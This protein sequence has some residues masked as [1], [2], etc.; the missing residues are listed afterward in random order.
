MP[1]YVSD[2]LKPIQTVK[3][4]FEKVEHR[5]AFANLIRQTLTDKTRYVWY[6]EMQEMSTAR[7]R[8]VE[9]E[10]KNDTADDPQEEEDDGIEVVNQ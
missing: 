1:E 2:N 6:P 10:E 3:V 5:N 8:Y 9:E 7:L 4:H